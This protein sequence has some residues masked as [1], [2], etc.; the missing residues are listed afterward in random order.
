VIDA[1]ILIPTFRHVR[2]L[3]LSLASALDQEGVEIEVLVV[4]DGVE[5]ATREVL[6]RHADDSRVRFFDFPKGARNGEAYRHRVLAEARSPVITYL[7]D[8]D[9]LLRDHVATMLVL[10]EDAHFAHSAT[11]WF[12]PGGLLRFHPWDVAR[13]EFGELMREG[14]NAI[15]LTATTHTLAAYRRLPVGWR[16]TP[17]RDPTD[18]HMWLQ[19]LAQP[20][21]RGVSSRTLT[22]LQFP[23]KSWGD[24]PEDEREGALAGWFERSRRPGFREEIDALLADAMRRAGEKYRLEAWRSAREIGV[25]ASTRTWRARQTVLSLLRRD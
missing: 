3:P 13:P 17:G 8:D 20:W 19:W 24:I 18:R 9:L 21:F 15:G 10:L 16:T 4:G 25:L 12:E 6:A 5:D 1:S 7:S 2:L 11:G 22:H 23:S 14:A